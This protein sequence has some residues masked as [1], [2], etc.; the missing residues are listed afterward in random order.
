M[1]KKPEAEKF[2]GVPVLPV[3]F[4][5]KQRLDCRGRGLGPRL[6]FSR[7]GVIRSILRSSI[8]R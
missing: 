1:L 5:K 6:I 8:T 4:S 3:R 2:A 7:P